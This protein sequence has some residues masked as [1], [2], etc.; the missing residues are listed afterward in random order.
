[1]KAE[2]KHRRV[3]KGGTS[4]RKGN[5]VGRILGTALV[6]LVIISTF[7]L[8]STALAQTI[9]LPQTGQTKC[10]DSSGIEINC[11]CTGQDGEIQ[12]GVPWP[13][14][15]FADHGDGTVTDHLTGLMWT[16]DA[17]LPGELKTWQE[18]LDYVAGM[19]TG[20][21]PNFGYNDWRLPNV[22]EL[23]SLMNVGKA[24][25]AGWLTNQAFINVHTYHYWSSTTGAKLVDYAWDIQAEDATVYLSPK[26]WDQYVWPVRSEQNGIISIPKTGQ[27]TS[28]YSGDDGYIQGGIAWPSPRFADHGDGTVTDHLTGLMWTKDADLADEPKTWQEA[29]NYVAGM[30][31]GTNPNF[32]Y[33]DWRL[34]NI[35]ELRSLIDHSQHD[36]A[37]QLGH[38][39]TNAPQA[40]QGRYWS[41]TTCL[42]C[43]SQENSDAYT[44]FIGFWGGVGSENKNVESYVYFWPVRGGQNKP[45]IPSNPSPPNHATGVSTNADLSWTGGDPDARD[46][47]TYDVYFGTSSTPYLVSN[48]Q[49][50]TT[51]DPGTL[52]YN[53]KYYWQIIAT[54]N[55]GALTTGPLWDFTTVLEEAERKLWGVPVDFRFI[56]DLQEGNDLPEVRYLQIVLNSDPGTQL[57]G[58]GAGSPGSETTTFGLL[59]KEA[60]IKFQLK[61]GIISSK[62]DAGA[63]RAGPKTR[64]KLN[65]IL[66][67]KFTKEYKEKFGLLDDRERKS[68]IWNN[69]KDDKNDYLPQDFPAELILAIA[70]QETGDYA[71]WNNEHVANDW[72]RGI[73]QVTTNTYV[74][75]GSGCTSEDCTKCKRDET[76]KKICCSKYYSNTLEGIE[77][78]IKDGLYALKE[79]YSDNAAASHY[80]QCISGEPDYDKCTA[81]NISCEEMRWISAVQRYHCYYEHPKD[82]PKEYLKGI[83]EK[84]E[85]LT[86]WFPSADSKVAVQLA[87]KVRKVWENSEQIMVFSPVDLRVYDSNGRITGLINGGISEGIPFSVCYQESKVIIIPFPDD[88]YRYQVVGTD[89]GTY[90]F[91]IAS[92][93]DGEATTFS[94]VDIPITSGA[95]HQYTIDWYAISEGEEGV[96]MEIDSNGDGTFEQSIESDAELTSDE[97][98][99]VEEEGELPFWIWVAIG[100]G[101]VAIL[102]AVIGRHLVR[103]RA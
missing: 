76:E 54:D 39:F 50:G 47:V 90:G 3:N 78:N 28:Y 100:A 45:N 23:E 35:K 95:V 86:S 75:A 99:A 93:K 64:A 29:L 48:D 24:S 77:A 71:H 7:I 87:E 69:I 16:K 20:T 12:G 42:G 41:S 84:L 65:E 58:E 44:C 63:G 92:T 21:N 72:G 52:A 26:T 56:T 13:S 46:T 22:N 43:T 98:A 88:S 51:Y 37:L 9:R 83:A 8:V 91:D 4:A 18:A 1:L 53:T 14:P 102:G 101:V 32:G 6:F 27:V 30:N 34:P 59:T 55:H 79:K 19:N 67:G 25:S 61:H 70:A 31:T 103:R 33:N 62:D 80:D 15:R 85:N 40:S 81:Y 82:D 2:G 73:M 74:G 57:A 66:D 60:V 10:Y 96:T 36:P 68:A 17:N 97:F 89:E 49:L 5:L 38:P 11:A 94:A